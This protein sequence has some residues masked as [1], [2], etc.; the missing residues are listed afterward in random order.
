MRHHFW[1]RRGHQGGSSARGRW[2]QRLSVGLLEEEDSRP[3]NRP[4]LR[5]SEEEAAGQA[6]PEGGARREVGHSWAERGRERG[7][8]R[9]GRKPKIVGSN[10]FEFYLEFRLNG[11]L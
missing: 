3:A 7:E 5:I 6:G 4:G 2:R 11:I 8:P 10:P 9:L 1:E